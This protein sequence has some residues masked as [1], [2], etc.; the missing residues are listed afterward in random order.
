MDRAGKM[1][2]EIKKML[3]STR[4]PLDK[5]QAKR[6]SLQE[7]KIIVNEMIQF[8]E[9]VVRC[10]EWLRKQRKFE[11]TYFERRDDG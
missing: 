4:L 7:S 2:R 9:A 10:E 5:L 6:E 11:E 3:H 1:G 8:E